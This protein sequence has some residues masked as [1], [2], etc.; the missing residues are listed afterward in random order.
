MSKR[1]K[2]DWPVLLQEFT[3]SG[4]TQAQFC[5]ERHINAKYFSLRRAKLLKEKQPAFV[6]AKIS[7]SPNSH[8][9]RQQTLLLKFPHVELHFDTS[10]DPAYISQLIKASL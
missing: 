10:T 5:V 8:S 1:Q 4:L 6:R 9:A 3:D 2:Y 7:A